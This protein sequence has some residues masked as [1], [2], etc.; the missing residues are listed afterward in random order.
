MEDRLVTSSDLS[1]SSVPMLQNDDDD[2]D[3]DDRQICGRGSTLN[4]KEEVFTNQID[5]Q[6]G[7]KPMETFSERKQDRLCSK[8]ETCNYSHAVR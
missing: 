6:L 4:E 8:A 2:D 7:N 5:F 3:N 1:R